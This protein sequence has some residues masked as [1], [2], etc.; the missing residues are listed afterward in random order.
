MSR[1]LEYRVNDD[2]D[3]HAIFRREGAPGQGQKAAQS[4]MAV[5]R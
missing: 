5:L 4:M 2:G 3:G 1:S